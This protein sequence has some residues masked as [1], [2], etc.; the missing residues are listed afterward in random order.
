[1]VEELEFPPAEASGN[2]VPCRYRVS[3]TGDTVPSME[4][5]DPGARLRDNGHDE[6]G[7]GERERAA[8]GGMPF[9]KL[10]I[11]HRRRHGAHGRREPI[12]QMLRKRLGELAAVRTGT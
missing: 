6:T 4:C 7:S 1:M 8:K 2:N 10:F 12:R 9:T 11:D 5:H 3:V